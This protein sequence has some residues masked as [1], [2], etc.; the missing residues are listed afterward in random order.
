MPETP[1][2]QYAFSTQLAARQLLEQGHTP[3]AVFAGTGLSQ[4][5]LDQEEPIAPFAAVAGF[6]SHAAE[7]SGDPLFGFRLGCGSDLRNTGL[8]GYIACSSPSVGCFLRNTARYAAVMSD[9]WELD[10]SRLASHGEFA[11]DCKDPAA[12]K[13]FQYT[14]FLA[15]T[16]FA[17]LR[18]AAPLRIEPREAAFSHLRSSGTAEIEAYFGCPVQFGAPRSRMVFK[19]EDLELPLASGDRRLLRLLRAYG[20]RLLGGQARQGSGLAAQ[21]EE[22]VSA[23]LS[24]GSVTLGTVAAD[25]GMSPR[26]LSR[27]LAQAGTSYFAILEELRK[28]LAIRY[29]RESDLAL[30]EIAFLLG[31]SG[32]SSFSEAF[33]RWTGKSPGQFRGR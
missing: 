2:P 32:L 3:A 21:V 18:E 26:T 5:L 14:E 30:A 20:D 19:P 16:F 9:V 15:A 28:T 10:T 11:W 29:L 24:G 12:R 7:L 4:A 8:L 25:L 33:R 1:P 17:A 6:F 22:A 31:Y 13:A 23:R 27:K